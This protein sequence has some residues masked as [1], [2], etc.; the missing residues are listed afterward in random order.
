MMISVFQRP[1]YSLASHPVSRLRL[2]PVLGAVLLG[3]ACPL[4]AATMTTY[5]WD[6]QRTNTGG[7]D[8]AATWTSTSTAMASQIADF[9]S[10][11]TGAD[12]VYNG[13]GGVTVVFGSGGSVGTGLIPVP[14]ARSASVMDLN[15]VAGTG[16]ITGYTFTQGGTTGAINVTTLAPDAPNT[17]TT[18]DIPITANIISFG[19][20]SSTLALASGST[21]LGV[22]TTSNTSPNIH[23]LAGDGQTAIAN[24]A[25]STISLTAG[26]YTIGTAIAIGN[27]TAG[28]YGMQVGSG[29]T[30]TTATTSPALTDLGIGGYNANGTGVLTINNGGTVS[31]GGTVYIQNNVNASSSTGALLTQAN[32]SGRLIVNS[33]GVLSG[34]KQIIV[35]NQFDGKTQSAELDVNGGTVSLLNTGNAA[36]S[37]LL[38]N[39]AVAAGTATVNIAGGTTTLGVNSGIVLNAGSSSVGSSTLNVS[40]GSLFLANGA[41]N[42]AIYNQ[43]GGTISVNFSGGTIGAVSAWSIGP[44][45]PISLTT[46]SNGNVTIQT[47]NQ[48][49]AGG[50]SAQSFTLAING[51]LSGT[52]GLNTSGAGTLILGGNNT[53]TGPTVVGAG[54]LQIN[55]AL[56]SSSVTVNAS[57]TLSLIS[58]SVLTGTSL[59]VNSTGTLTLSNTTAANA[60]NGPTVMLLGGSTL[61]LAGTNG[62]TEAV[63]MLMLDGMTVPANTYTPAQLMAMDNAINFEGTESLI[64]LN[65]APVPEPG[66]LGLLG[67]AAAAGLGFARPRRR[68]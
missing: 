52:G 49:A 42:G 3:S 8:G 4:S 40:G 47:S 12:A 18:F 54:T 48:G 5:T 30:L 14:T 27:A 68:C 32:L 46:G 13:N 23:G 61:N 11:T 51:V 67:V 65:P 29:A 43:G 66:T 28:T 36:G 56:A 1:V 58:G 59:T 62:T 20:P 39:N 2:L 60:S 57:G 16:S 9:Y 25:S 6:E 33:G 21:Q 15:A 55:G 34:S 31:T 37:I 35:G 44:S 24:G 26:M 7:S 63:N 19:A 10:S 38:N 17:L 50:A 64:V 22:D 53:Y 45:I 41:N